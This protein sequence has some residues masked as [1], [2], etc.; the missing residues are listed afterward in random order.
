[1]MYMKSQ[2]KAAELMADWTLSM[3]DQTYFGFCMSH[4]QCCTSWLEGLES[5]Q[6]LEAA[7]TLHLHAASLMANKAGIDMHD[8]AK[9][10]AKA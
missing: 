7:V 8:C 4:L 3:A 6:E 10:D 2:S 5:C 1:M 9:T